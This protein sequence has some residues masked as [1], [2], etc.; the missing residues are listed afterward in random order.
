[1]AK[2]NKAKMQIHKKDSNVGVWA[3]DIVSVGTVYQCLALGCTLHSISIDNILRLGMSPK[4][5]HML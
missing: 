3:E 4:C 2:G 1:M 5:S